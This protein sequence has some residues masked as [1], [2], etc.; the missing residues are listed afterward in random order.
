M[1]A[2]PALY[3]G[4][5]WVPVRYV[6]TVS[7]PTFTAAALDSCTQTHRR[8]RAGLKDTEP[9]CIYTIISKPIHFLITYNEDWFTIT[10]PAGNRTG[11]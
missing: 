2:V 10:G 7:V 3:I 11:S 8:P 5:N 6:G 4:T 1:R 9:S